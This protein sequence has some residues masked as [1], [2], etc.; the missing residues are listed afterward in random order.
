MTRSS[1]AA[2]SPGRAPAQPA[3]RAAAL[4]D[5][6]AGAA[7]ST[8]FALAW[9]VLSWWHPAVTYHFG[10]PLATAAWPVSLRARVRHPASAGQ[11]LAAVG[12]GF[13]IAMA[14]L[15]VAM[16]ARWLRGPTLA[17]GGSV[18][19]EEVVLAVAAAA[20]GWRV[21]GRRRRAWFL[22]AEPARRDGPAAPG[23]EP[24]QERRPTVSGR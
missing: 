5:H 6:V 23:T 21:A 20:W 18:P 10:P 24:G 7:A 19:A 9:L 13:L 11:A 8:G 22:P 16:A 4:F 2:H 1:P 12:G 14:A 17:G 3:G 15:G